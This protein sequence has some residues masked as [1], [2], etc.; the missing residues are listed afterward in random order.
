MK[1]ITKLLIILFI[2]SIIIILAMGIGSVYIPPIHTINIIVYKIFGHSFLPIENT[3]MAI[4]LKVRIP[5]V[6]LA[7]ICGGGLALSGSIMQA[8][9]KNPLA[10]SYTLGVSSGSAIG[11]S[12]VI[13]FNVSMFGIF[14]LQVF[15]SIF[16]IFTVILSVLLASK[17]DKNFQNNTIILTG[18]AFSLF[19]NAV[20][21]IFLTFAKENLKSL[22]FWQMGSFSGK[23]SVY[24][25][26]LYPMIFIIFLLLI[27]NYKEID[28]MSFGDNEAIVSGVDTKKSK[29]IYLILSSILSGIVV[30]VCGIIGFVDLFTPHISRKIFGA[31][32]KY[33]FPICILL[34]GIFM[35]LCDLLAR[36]LVSPRELPVGAITSFIGAPFFIYLYFR[37]RK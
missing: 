1:N 36:S 28:I 13:L 30:S 23:D 20:L 29:W 21:S 31:S 26:I 35:V 2:G 32:H 25:Y 34:G 22:I 19:S 9:L 18:M 14:S 5:R 24:L 7:F 6:F 16:G 37:K 27:I 4:L 11:A 8:I 10:S 3:S 12:L 33:V 15:G 17:I